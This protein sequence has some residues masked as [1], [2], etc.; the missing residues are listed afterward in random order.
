VAGAFPL[1]RALAHMHLADFIS[2]VEPY[3]V[4]TTVELEETSAGVRMR[5]TFDPMHD[6]EWTKRATM[7]WES[8]LGKLGGADRAAPRRRQAMTAG[9]LSVSP[10]PQRAPA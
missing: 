1:S 9:P 10:H 5:L 3:D 6:E 7:G 4:A 8:E 2:G